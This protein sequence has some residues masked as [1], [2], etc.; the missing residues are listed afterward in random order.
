MQLQRNKKYRPT[1]LMAVMGSTPPHE[2]REGGASSKARV[3]GG[4][5]AP[6][7]PDCLQGCGA[8]WRMQAAALAH[9]GPQTKAVLA[10]ASPGN[11]NPRT[12]FPGPRVFLV[13]WAGGPRNIFPSGLAGKVSPPAGQAQVQCRG[14]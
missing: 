10:A 11:E 12:E 5:G 3:G 13:G 4:E 7:F 2:T 1:V 14:S 9:Q 6:A 8:W